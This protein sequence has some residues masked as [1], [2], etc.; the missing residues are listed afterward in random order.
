[1]SSIV[2]LLCTLSVH[3]VPKAEP[4]MEDRHLQC[5]CWACTSYDKLLHHPDYVR[6]F[7]ENVFLCLLFH[8]RV[9]SGGLE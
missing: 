7:I 8:S 3:C 6:I 2:R 1:M 4:D 5:D 9:W